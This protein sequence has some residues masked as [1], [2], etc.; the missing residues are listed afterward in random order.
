MERMAGWK[1]NKAWY[2][3]PVVGA[4]IPAVVMMNRRRAF[5]EE[6]K[7]SNDRALIDESNLDL[8]QALHTALKYVPGTPIEV[9]LEAEHG[10]PVWEV[11]IVPKKGGPTRE[12]RI[13][14]KTGDLLE[15]KAEFSEKRD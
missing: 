12:V 5:I 13:D 7:E 6:V 4:A 10:M 2:A 14:A 8:T 1:W 15:M 11:E 3:L 9:E